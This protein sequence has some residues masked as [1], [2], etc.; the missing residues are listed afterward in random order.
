MT[1]QLRHRYCA[2]AQQPSCACRF[3]FP[4]SLDAPTAVCERMVSFEQS[5]C[6]NSRFDC[7][8]S[9]SSARNRA[10]DHPG[11]C[12]DR[13][14]STPPA[15]GDTHDLDPA[16]Q[17]RIGDHRRGERQPGARC[18]RRQRQRAAAPG[19]ARRPAAGVTITVVLASDPPPKAALDEF[20]KET[21][22][23]V[24]WT[25][26]DWDSLQT[27]ISAAATAEH[28]L[29]RRHRRRLVAGRT[30]RPSSAGSPDG[31]ATRHQVHG[32]R[33]A[34]ARFVHRRRP[35]GRHALRRLVHGHH[36]QQGD[37]RQ[38]RRIPRRRRWTRTPSR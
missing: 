21:G 28:L 6:S 22:I 11:R 5:R 27:K 4:E 20:T 8:F 18:L 25:N 16:H 24:N 10:D 30:V 36:D 9:A 19:R 15:E 12:D 14:T 17:S 35:R 37:V 3:D 34:P 31:D 33:H 38:G 13:R 29:R 7:S 32:S 1:R 23:T 26:V 2:F